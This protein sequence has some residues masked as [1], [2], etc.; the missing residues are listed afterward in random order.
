M[1]CSNEL[2]LYLFSLNGPVCMMIDL[3]STFFSLFFNIFLS[4]F[5]QLVA[6]YFQRL[7]F[8]WFHRYILCIHCADKSSVSVHV[9]VRLLNSYFFFVF[10]IIETKIVCVIKGYDERVVRQNNIKIWMV[11]KRL[12]KYLAE[13][14]CGF[15]RYAKFHHWFIV[16]LKH[17]TVTVVSFGFLFIFFYKCTFRFS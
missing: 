15:D 11:E 5:I 4:P 10:A 17:S 2:F 13:I 7:F 6:I 9:Y 8:N 14:S 3:N 16:H 1:L 12:R